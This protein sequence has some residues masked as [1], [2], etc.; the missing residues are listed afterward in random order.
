MSAPDVTPGVPPA[1]TTLVDAGATET[2]ATE[3]GA[4]GLPTKPEV[5]SWRLVLTLGV[6]AV[7]SALGLSV[8][9]ELT[10]P[11]IAENR[12]RVLREAVDEV[13]GKPE[14]VVSLVVGAEGLVRD[15]EVVYTEAKGVERVYLGY[16]DAEGTQPIGFALV[17]AAY[18]Y[19]S[20]PI[21]LAFGYDPT[22]EEILGLKVLE[23]K[24]TPGISLTT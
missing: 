10:A 14:A 1:D 8:V 19:G 24:E 9:N 18:G 3:S 12:A 15:D 13:L 2:G 22:T 11:A 17:G 7:L 6:A 5:P 4:A 20:D 16:A 21:K 23:H